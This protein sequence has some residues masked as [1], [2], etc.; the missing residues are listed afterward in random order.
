M[1]IEDL[2]ESIFKDNYISIAVDEYLKFKLTDEYSEQYKEVALKEVN[3]YMLDKKITSENIQEIIKYFQKKNPQGGSFVHWSN[4]SDLSQYAESNPIEVTELLN[5]L[6]E[7]SVD[8]EDRIE[9]FLKGGKAYDRKISLGTPLFGY[10][11]AGFNLEKY[12]LYKDNIFRDFLN[13]FG[14]NETLGTIPIKYSNYYNLCLILLDH[15]KEN[16]ISRCI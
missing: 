9:R 6:Y 12:P 8:I 4:L 1:R 10:L 5:Y 13:T 15:F 14:I 2:K 16:N 3:K 7:D 11:L